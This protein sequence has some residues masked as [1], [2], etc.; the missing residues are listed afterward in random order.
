MN[1]LEAGLY[2]QDVAPPYCLPR[3]EGCESKDASKKQSREP[4]SMNMYGRN[5]GHRY[6]AKK[7]R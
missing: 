3:E 7:D 5:Q 6:E 1:R 4:K 2:R